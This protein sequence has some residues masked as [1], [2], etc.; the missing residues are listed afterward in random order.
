MNPANIFKTLIVVV[1]FAYLSVNDQQAEART[2]SDLQ[3]LDTRNINMNDLNTMVQ[4]IDDSKLSSNPMEQA[5]NDDDN[6]DDDDRSNLQVQNPLMV[7]P[8]ASLYNDNQSIQPILAEQTTQQHN[9][10]GSP[11]GN[12]LKTSA[13][14]H[15]H[16]HG[17]KGWLDMGA[18]TGK[19]GAFGWHDKHPVGG[20]G[21]K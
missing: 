10:I 13:S 12:D 3:N 6:D 7:S 17:V 5:D 4:L 16:G 20:K 14:H 21:R 9:K 18:W 19:K 15:H 11:S 2:F 1:V 8:S